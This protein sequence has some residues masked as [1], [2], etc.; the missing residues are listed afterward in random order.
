MTNIKWITVM[1]LLVLIPLI[2][3]DQYIL[4]ILAEIFIWGTMSMSL[5]L[6]IRAGIFNLGHAAFM[7]LGAYTSALLVTKGGFSFWLTLPIAGALATIVAILIGIPI[8]RLKGMYFVLVTCALGEVVKLLIASFP[9]ITRGYDGIHGIPAPRLL[10]IDFNNKVAYYYLVLAF[11]VVSTFICY[12]VWHS[13]IGK[14]FRG[15]AGNELLCESIGIPSA[16]YKIM[17]FAIASFIAS[18]CGCFITILSSTIDPL[19]FGLGSSVNCFLYMVLGGVGS[20]F[21]PIVGA[22]VAIILNELLRFMLELTPAVLGV[23][24]IL[25]IIFLPGGLISLPKRFLRD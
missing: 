2:T 9:S 14:I 24:V 16:F 21:G 1:G 13:Q 23:I 8:L 5:L 6:T 7:A 25:I 11:M 17:S 18:L 15:I 3:T 19:M 22:T 12:R 4:Y 20:I 10:M